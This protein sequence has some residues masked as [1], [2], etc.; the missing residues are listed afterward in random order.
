[1]NARAAGAAADAAFAGLRQL[2]WPAATPALLE[3]AEGRVLDLNPAAEALFA[4]QGQGWVGRETTRLLPEAH[5]AEA[6]AQRLQRNRQAARGEPADPVRLR[7]DDAQGRPRWFAAAP[8]N[9]AGDSARPRWLFLLHEVTGEVQAL[10]DKRNAEAERDRAHHQVATLMHSASVMV[11]SYDPVHGWQLPTPVAAAGASPLAGAGTAALGSLVA[12]VRSEFVRPA[13]RPEFDRLQAA[14][15]EGL[16]AEVRFALEHPELGERWLQV[17]VAP[18]IHADGHRSSTVAMVDVTTR[19]RALA[20]AERLLRERELMFNLSEVGI[21]VWRGSRVERANG[22]MARLTGF[23]TTELMALDPVALHAD[24]RSGVEFEKQVGQALRQQGRYSGE[25]RLR[26]KGGGERWVH[27]TVREIADAGADAAGPL[28][29]SL[30]GSFVDIDEK[31]RSREAL[32]RQ[33]DRT[34]AVLNSV[35]VGIVTVGESGIVWLNRSARRMF[36]GYLSD[37]VDRPMADV[38]TPDPDHPLRRSDWMSR[39]QEG[40]SETFECQLQARDGRRF[41]VAGNAVLTHPEGGERQVTF[42]L[43]DI[44]RRRQAETRTAAARTRLQRLIDTAP[45]AI[46]LFEPQALR[47]QQANAAAAGF[48]ARSA[49]PGCLPEDCCTPAQAAALRRWCADAMSGLAGSHEWT[50]DS[51]PAADAA[52][53]T[54]WDCRVALLTPDDDPAAATDPVLLLVA[55]DVTEQRA[56]ERSRLAAAIEQREVLVREVHHRIKNNLQGVAGLLQHNARQHPEVATQLIEAVSQVQT[57][58]QVH[59]LQVGGHGP[60][61]LSGLL[62]AVVVAVQRTYDH[63]IQVV[64]GDRLAELPEA[65]AIP[66]ALVLNELLTNAIKHG[67]DSPVCCELVATPGAPGQAGVRVTVSNT[68]ALPS[69]FSIAG[70]RG[71]VTGL[72][73]VRALLPRRGSRFELVAKGALVVAEVELRPPHV[74]WP[75]PPADASG[76]AGSTALGAQP[77]D[78]T[79]S[80]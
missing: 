43:L 53:A 75:Q 42:A 35:L 46:A 31:R 79:M 54:V 2:L 47:V 61:V 34:R 60:I 29:G 39:L 18:V 4:P 28:A 56:A 1:M 19:E 17:N 10:R 45:L 13:M 22:A 9:V 41:W 78:P 6:V 72:G 27:A 76:A 64:D 57:I 59:G 20:E 68:G 55:S 52:A 32:A 70:I 25:H 36:G 24:A 8:H 69:G 23:A 66:I 3:S 14:L 21:L 49:L 7:V 30:I 73:L 37:F 16:A 50:L 5:R 48:F 26:L 38:A 12:G 62:D 11:A 71:G 67:R 74:R 33:A 63:P 77:P 44:E 80:R 40:Q 58:A 65:E 15:R 51:E